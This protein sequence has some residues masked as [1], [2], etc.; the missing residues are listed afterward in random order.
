MRTSG[1]LL[2]IFSLPGK[3]GIGCFSKA[4]YDF[5]DFLAK[6]NQT[7]WQIL[8]L[9]PTSYGDSPYQSFSTFAGNPYFI[10]LE[11][12]IEEG[13]LTD[14]E[15]NEVDFGKSDN[16]IDYEILYKNRFSLLKK[17]YKR[18][19]LTLD[20]EY[21]EFIEKNQYWIEDYALYMS[22]K[23]HF[24]D[25]CF[26]EWD[27]DI[28]KRDEEAIN[29]YQVELKDD[30]NFYK[31]LQYKFMQQWMELK[32]Y[33]NSKNV[34]IIG[35]IPIYVSFD[36]SETWAHPELFELDEE[37]RLISVAGCPPDGFS[38]DGQLWGNP[39][40]RWDYHKETDYSWW[41]LRMEKCKEL[42][43]VIRI[44]HFRGFD[45]FYSIPANATTAKEGKWRK[46]PGISLFNSLKEILSDINIIAEDLGF[47]TDTVKKLVKDTGFPN[48]KVLEFAF[49][50]RDTGNSSDYLPHNYVKNSV[51]YTGTHDNETVVGWLENITE[52]ELASVKRYFDYSGDDAAELT[53]KIIRYA[54][55]SVADTCIIP[56]QDYL[57]LDNSARIN[58]PSTLGNNWVWRMNYEDINDEL[59]KK[60]GELTV[61]YGR[62]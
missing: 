8:P 34:K 27:E 40:Y 43:D 23:N 10:S 54:H 44:D 26:Q 56:M 3:Y 41:K 16:H 5:V 58:T 52:K 11:G 36:S 9:G 32:K 33:A 45:E 15:C 46:G 48:M 1:I 2:P 30:I 53:D 29:R 18:A 21:E 60:L 38:A 61:L 57:H 24:G 31:F 51:V 12:L 19:N 14:K 20:K 39:I 42:Y 6:S 47:V 7:Y 4:A 25:V 35:D 50:E 37:K 49:D 17:A 55:L 13:L 28:K 59:S 22:V 62:G